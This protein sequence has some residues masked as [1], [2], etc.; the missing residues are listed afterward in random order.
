MNSV[1]MLQSL[2]GPLD[3]S[4]CNYFYYMSI[5]FFAILCFTAFNLAKKVFSGKKVAV[6]E[7]VIVL[8]QPFLLYF[9]NRLYFSM[10]VGS[11]R[12]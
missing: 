2:F 8:L 10:C 5:F 12:N 9:I 7:M 3:A 6:Q 1:N 11:L 4:Y